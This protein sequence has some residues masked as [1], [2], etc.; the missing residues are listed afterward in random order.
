MEHRQKLV[1]WGASGHALVVA[2]I[3]RLV[4]EYEIVGFLDDINPDRHN[5]QF[6][7]ARVLGGQEQLDVLQRMGVRHLIFGLGN[8]EAR[9]RLSALVSKKGFS[10][11]TAVHPCATVAID[12]PVGQGTVIAAGAVVNPGS[13]IGENVIVNTCAS[14]DHECVIG[15][16]AHICPG[17]NLAGGVTVG[18]GAWIGIGAVVVNR[19]RIGAGAFVGAGAVVTKDIPDGVIAHGVPARVISKTVRDD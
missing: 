3:V 16:G 14:V 5:A 18:R 8:C 4:G 12:V 13:R 19:V 2:D 7:G 6:C 9:L 1:I 11:A 17:V 10:L 15:D